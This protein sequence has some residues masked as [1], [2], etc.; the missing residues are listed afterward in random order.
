MASFN[1]TGRGTPAR[2]HAAGVSA[3]FFATLGVSPQLGRGFTAEED[4][5]NGPNAVILMHSFWE[6]YFGSDPSVL[7]KAITL[8]GAPYS[9]VAV[10]PPSFRF[11]GEADIQMLTP[12]ALN[13]AQ[14]RL[15]MMVN[16]VSIIGRL[17]PGANVARALTDLDA[18][19][20]R[21]ESAGEQPGVGP[22]AAPA[23]GPS[24]AQSRPPGGGPALPQAGPGG[25][26]QLG[27]HVAGSGPGNRPI[28]GR[29]ESQL[30][31]VALGEHL[32]GNLRPA[33][34]TLLGVVG[35]VLLIACAN[36]A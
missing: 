18:I 12:L 9:V 4:R 14:Q 36:V 19:R 28:G 32:A 15:R 27:E 33:M 29:P 16:L 7:G 5:P 21:A 10:M 23:P 8:N 34:L 17:K 3:N 24:R 26:R 31:V 22:M 6:Q 20:K 2:V 35:P 11:P 13:E 1:M 30:K 25:G